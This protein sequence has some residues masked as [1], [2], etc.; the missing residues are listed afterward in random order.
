MNVFITILFNITIKTTKK[1]LKQICKMTELTVAKTTTFTLLATELI[2]KKHEA[3][4][5]RDIWAN[6]TWKNIN[7]L[8]NDDVG[9]VGEEI[10]DN[11][12]KMASID[13]EIDGKKTK[14]VGGGSGDGLIKGRTCE[15]KTARVGSSG[16]TFQHELGEEPWKAEFMIFLD[17]APEKMYVTLFKNFT[18]DFYKTSGVNNSIK[19]EPYFP[20]KSITWRKQK[21]AFKLDTSVAINEKNGYTFNFDNT[22]DDWT[23]FK[24][25]VDRIIT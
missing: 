5:K 22:I 1:I 4:Q 24:E 17:I 2:N 10:I 19:C 23:K 25:F 13:S 20:T 9:G 18:E 14:M 7:E 3:K 6:S 8:E 15:I 11:F 21:G 12:C 16:G